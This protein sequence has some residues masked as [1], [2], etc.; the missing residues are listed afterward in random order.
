[1][2]MGLETREHKGGNK[3]P[4]KIIHDCNTFWLSN[5]CLE[6]IGAENLVETPYH[7]AV[8]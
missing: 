5:S 1:M 2:V 3:V 6:A 8:G 4:I 7:L